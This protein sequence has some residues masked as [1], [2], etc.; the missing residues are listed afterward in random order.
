MARKYRKRRRYRRRSFRRRNRRMS[1]RRRGSSTEVKYWTNTL[2]NQSCKLAINSVTSDSLY[3]E[4]TYLSNILTEIVQG[5]GS[6]SRIGNKIYVMSINVRMLIY[7]CPADDDYSAG[8][9]LSRHIWHNSPNTAG[10]GVPDFFLAPAKVNFHQMPDRRMYNVHYD[11]VY[12]VRAHE[13]TTSQITPYETVG[14]VKMIN[15]SV[16]V[17]RYVTYT[18]FNKPKE[19]YNV[20]SLAVL[21]ATP[22]M[23]NSLYNNRQIGCYQ[24][25]YRI[26]FKDA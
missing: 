11:K 25:S 3:A 15:Y 18:L 26:Y 20:Y 1:Y 10:A 14:A 19:D 13:S 12:T 24:L 17:N 8:T 6:G 21:T 4:Q 7:S 9:F 2:E 16:P 22:G 23:S 5:T